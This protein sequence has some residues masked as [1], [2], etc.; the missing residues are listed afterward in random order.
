[1]NRLSVRPV[2]DGGAPSVAP[3][4]PIA[5]RLMSIDSGGIAARP[6]M[7]SV[8]PK[9]RGERAMPRRNITGGARPSNG[10]DRAAPTCHAREREHLE[11]YDATRLALLRFRRLPGLCRRFIV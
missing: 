3:M 5:G 6:A 8:K 9:E 11:Y 1:M 2:C 4:A 7:R 10:R